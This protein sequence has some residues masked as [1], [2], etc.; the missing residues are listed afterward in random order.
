MKEVT[1]I[2]DISKIIKKLKLA[3]RNLKRY[4]EQSDPKIQIEDP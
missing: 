3:T 4:N 2:L 1:K